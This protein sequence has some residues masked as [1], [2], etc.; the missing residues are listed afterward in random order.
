M[1]FMMVAGTVA[2]DAHG[3]RISVDRRRPW[4]W[5]AAPR[6]LGLAILSPILVN[7]LAFHVLLM[8]GEG[9]APGVV[10]AALAG[11]LIY[12]YRAHFRGLLTTRA[13]P[14]P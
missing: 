4:C 14:T 11:F 12:A 9:L 2:L 8:G 7:I 10:F 3:R 1:Q 6:P 13:R 5:R